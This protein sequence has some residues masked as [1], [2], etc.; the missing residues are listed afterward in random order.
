MPP[1]KGTLENR[2]T[3]LAPIPRQPLSLNP[4]ASVF[5]N[6]AASRSRRRASSTR[7]TASVGELKT[8]FA[9]MRKTV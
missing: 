1:G 2:V 9:G 6:Q 5:L 4:R 3:L 7:L 8:T